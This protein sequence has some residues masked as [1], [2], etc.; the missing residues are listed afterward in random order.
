MRR[1]PFHFFPLQPD[2]LASKAREAVRITDGNANV[3]NMHAL[4]TLEEETQHAQVFFKGF[5]GDAMMGFALQPPF[6]ADYD[7]ATWRDAHLAVHRSQGVLNYE[8]EELDALLAP[9]VR[10]QLN[11]AVWESY[12]AA[13]SQSES[14][15]MALQRLQFDY[16]QRVPRM[17]LNGVEAVRS[18]AAARLPFAD[19]DLIDFVLTIPP[20]WLY[21]RRL[22]QDALVRAYPDLCKVPTT[23]TGFPLISCARDVQL[24]AKQWL[25]WQMNAR[26][27]G[28]IAPRMRR[29]YK[30][31]ATWFRTTLRPWVEDLLLSPRFLERGYFEEDVVRRLVEEH[32][33]GQNHAVRLGALISLELWHQ[34]FID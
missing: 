6:W 12:H 7:A 31:Y 4:A 1:V 15:Q 22:V 17:T 24:R 8:P 30:D 10:R 14:S 33:A 23:T 9:S 11:G 21:Q 28:R 29:P 2:W 20:G 3:V 26:G 19:N 13:M 16:Q 34:E 5:L 32:M 25:S 18:R 27:L